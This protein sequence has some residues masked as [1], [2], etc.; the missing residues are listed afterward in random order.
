MEE[1]RKDTLNKLNWSLLPFDALI[2]VA[3]VFEIGPVKYGGSRTW[4]P[5][6]SYSKLFSAIIRHLVSWFYYREE[7]DRESGKRHLAHI[8]ANALM[9]LGCKDNKDFDDRP[10]Q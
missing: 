2:E 10:K 9:L 7:M 1:G 6:I 8:A 3:E 4:L 5:G